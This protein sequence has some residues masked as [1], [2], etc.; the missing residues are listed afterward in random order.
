MHTEEQ[1]LA[2]NPEIR[3]PQLYSTLTKL[4]ALLENGLVLARS[5]DH[6]PPPGIATSRRVRALATSIL[7]AIPEDPAIQTLDFDGHRKRLSSNLKK[8][9][10][11]CK[12]NWHDGGDEQ[13]EYMGQISA[14]IGQWLPTIWDILQMGGYFHLA[15]TCVAYCTEIIQG[16]GRC[17]SRCALD[18]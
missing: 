2:T 15:R 12:N 11:S 10:S 3:D 14:D 6:I 13:A 9:E 8:L 1:V 7:N 5:V 18:V 16:I 17:E 4:T